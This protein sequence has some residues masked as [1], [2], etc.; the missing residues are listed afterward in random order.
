VKPEAIAMEVPAVVEEPKVV[1]EPTVMEVPKSPIEAAQ[2]I[3]DGEQPEQIPKETVE[4]AAN[5]DGTSQT[6][7]LKCILSFGCPTSH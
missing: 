6:A 1:E 5:I 2:E 7:T 4:P 3:Q